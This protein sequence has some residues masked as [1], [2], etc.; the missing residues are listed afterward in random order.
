MEVRSASSES[1]K[2]VKWN[3]ED[4][5]KWLRRT[6]GANY[7]DFQERLQHL[8]VAIFSSFVRIFIER[9]KHF[10]VCV[11][12][13]CQP[14]ITDAAK[15]SVEGICKK[16]YTLSADYAHKVNE[17]NLEIMKEANI[18]GMDRKYIFKCFFF[19]NHYSFFQTRT[20]RQPCRISARSGATRSSLPCLVPDCPWSSSSKTKNRHSSATKAKSRGSTATISASW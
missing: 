14:H 7:D 8:K 19:L 1:R 9:L 17:K 18:S 2:I 11:Q 6:V 20:Q 3:V 15:S 16:I 10:F 13:Q 4:T 5:F 12:T